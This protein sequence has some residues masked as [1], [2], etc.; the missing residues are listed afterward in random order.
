MHSIDRLRRAVNG[1]DTG[2]QSPKKPS[3]PT[4]HEVRLLVS[5]LPGTESETRHAINI[6]LDR[7]DPDADLGDQL[8]RYTYEMTPSE[9]REFFTMARRL[10]RLRAGFDR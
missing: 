1:E 9:E 7:L 4:A 3:D 5:G 10:V 6:I 8:A 2:R